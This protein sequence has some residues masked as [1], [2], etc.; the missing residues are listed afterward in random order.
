MG[1]SKNTASNK[2]S[3]VKNTPKIAPAANH[4]TFDAGNFVLCPS[5]GNEVYKLFF[6][7][8]CGCLGFITNGEIYHY[9]IDGKVSADDQIPSLFH[10]TKANRQAIATL[11]QSNP[12]ETN[13]IVMPVDVL[14]S[15]AS[16][17][18]GASQA[19]HDVSLLLHMIHQEKIN[20]RQVIALARLSHDSTNIWSD[21]LYHS[22]E[23]V[24][25]TIA[26]VST[27][28]VGV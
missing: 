19:L 5:V 22:L 7:E 17:M 1:N 18:D 2:T 13:D 28:S 11:Y 10:D 23:S 26:S 3:K 16:E 9:A 20:P 8:E 24:N 14:K 27:A 21:L 25:Q 15:I 6:D 4:I 12:I